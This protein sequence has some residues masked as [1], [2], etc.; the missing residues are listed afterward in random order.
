MIAPPAVGERCNREIRMLPKSNKSPQYLQVL[1]SDHPEHQSG[2]GDSAGL[3][4]QLAHGL[5]R[6]D[7]SVG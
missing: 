7:S 5:R 6:A 1:V 3:R 4:L 2:S